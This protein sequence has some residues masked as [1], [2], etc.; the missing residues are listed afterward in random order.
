MD[1][2]AQLQVGERRQGPKIYAVISGTL[3][4]KLKG[5][6]V[7]RTGTLAYTFAKHGGAWKIETEAW[8]R[9]S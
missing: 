7:V 3:T 6:S 1:L 5:Q 4:V 2:A 9:T 8:G